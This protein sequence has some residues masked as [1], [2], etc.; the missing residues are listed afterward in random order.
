MNYKYW[1]VHNPNNSKPTMR[2]DT[3]KAAFDEAE[4][5]AAANPGQTFYVLES[6]Y[7]FC[8]EKPRVVRESIEAAP[9]PAPE[10][11]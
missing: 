9:M 7:S 3:V 8:T 10:V 2:H 1:M 5:L 11:G 4:R 6:T